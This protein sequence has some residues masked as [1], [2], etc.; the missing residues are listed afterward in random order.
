MSQIRA[1][2]SDPGVPERFVIR[3]V[4]APAP[5]PSEA[6][7]QV[8]AVSLNRGEVRMSLAANTI[9]RPGWDIAGVVVQ[10][11]ADGSGPKVGTRVAGIARSGGWA[12]QVAIPTPQLGEIP[13][14]VSFAQA[15]TLPVA[16]LTALHS[17]WKGGFLLERP[18]L[19]TGATGGVGDYAIQL[20]RL[21]GA[22][23]VAHIR[24]PDQEGIVR[25]AGAH[26]VAVS[27]DLAEARKYGPYYFILDSVGGKV[28][29]DA[30]ELID[31]GGKIVSI[32]TSGGNQ[33][34]FNADRFYSI[35]MVT[36]YGLILFDELKTVEAASFGLKRLAGLIA[37]GK[38]SPRI[39]VEAD[40]TEV[41]NIA[42]QLMD[43]SYPGKAVL[44]LA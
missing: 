43:R 36:L 27:E 12:E 22:K 25:E 4:D 30:M 11:A 29:A 20:A 31:E 7:V 13:E 23:V 16:G 18:V 21:A 14:A 2:V 15:S 35:G 28:L 39:S 40:W 10:Q 17:L 1:V 19:I 26:F 3:E 44:H 34:T 8:K 5:H 37:D 42:R 32:G 41:A 9:R 33:V 38:L 24:K 6:L